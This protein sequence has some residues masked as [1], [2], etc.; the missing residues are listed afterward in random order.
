MPAQST[1]RLIFTSSNGSIYIQ[2]TEVAFLDAAGNDLAVGGIASASSTYGAGYEAAKAFD[3][4]AAAD[5]C[6]AV[7]EPPPHW[8]QYTHATPVEVAWVRI[9]C[10]AKS[11][12][13][14]PNAYTISLRAGANQEDRYDLSIASGAFSPNAVVVLNV[15]PHIPPQ[16]SLQPGAIVMSGGLSAPAGPVLQPQALRLDMQDVGMYRIYGTVKKKATQAPL[17]RRVQLL[18][19]RGSRLVRETWSD[20][21]TGAYSFD[22]IKGGP[23]ELYFVCAFDH[24]NT[25]LAVIAEKLIPEAMNV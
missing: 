22:Y 16:G 14:P 2:L 7:R 3:K 4:S 11:E 23:D 18:H 20:A 5:W 1:W 13:L 15:T 12:W 8:L 24:T 25:D 19:Q 9:T 21:S 17:R 6:T 10:S